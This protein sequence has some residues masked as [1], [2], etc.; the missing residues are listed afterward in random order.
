MK[1]IKEV[2]VFIGTIVFSHIFFL[3]NKTFLTS[4]FS[5][6]TNQV[7]FEYTYSDTLS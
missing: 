1:K 4:A 5:L 2:K 7:N 3:L 6:G